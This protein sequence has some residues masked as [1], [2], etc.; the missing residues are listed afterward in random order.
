[1]GKLPVEILTMDDG[2]EYFCGFLFDITH[3]RRCRKREQR[4]IDA[5]KKAESELAA[6]EKRYRIIMEQAADPIFDYNLKTHQVYCS[7]SF[8]NKLDFN[9]FGETI[10]TN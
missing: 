3:E 5:L 2:E 4:Q 7:P 9:A 6:S 1:M 8:Q 10:S